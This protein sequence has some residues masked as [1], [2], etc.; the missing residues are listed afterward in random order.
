MTFGLHEI[1]AAQAAGAAGVAAIDLAT[2]VDAN[3]GSCRFD[4][5]GLPN[6]TRLPGCRVTR[7]SA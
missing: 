6:A 7:P 4:V 1:V 5:M 3:C 2:R